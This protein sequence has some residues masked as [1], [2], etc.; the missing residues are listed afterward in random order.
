[1]TLKNGYGFLRKILMGRNGNGEGVLA[2]W[3]Y[4][5]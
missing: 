1:M 4:D 2:L 3:V 5:H